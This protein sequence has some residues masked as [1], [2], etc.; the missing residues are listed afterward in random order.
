M[1][2]RP[3]GQSSRPNLVVRRRATCSAPTTANAAAVAART[4]DRAAGSSRRTSS[5]ARPAVTRS[6][7]TRAD[8][9]RVLTLPSA[10]RLQD[11]RQHQESKRRR[12][13]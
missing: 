13:P 4:R 2:W 10:L 7:P 8:R 3:C 11:K 12:P 1:R 5:R 9:I 6:A